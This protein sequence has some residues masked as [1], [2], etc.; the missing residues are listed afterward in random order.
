MSQA[1]QLTHVEKLNRA[2]DIGMRAINQ[3]LWNNS[4]ESTINDSKDLKAACVQLVRLVASQ[5]N[6]DGAERILIKNPPRISETETLAAQQVLNLASITTKAPRD[7]V[8][9]LAHKTSER[10]R[11]STQYGLGGTAG[12]F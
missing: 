9:D 11:D 3:W 10:L 12:P 4:T 1:S 2:N 6:M 7:L 8:W 5:I